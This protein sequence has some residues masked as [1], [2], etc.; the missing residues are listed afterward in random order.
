MEK[1]DVI[2][3]LTEVA[4]LTVSVNKMYAQLQL[5]RSAI[6]T[7]IHE[8]ETTP[9]APDEPAWLIEYLQGVLENLK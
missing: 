9:D 4:S 3:T 7:A 6:Q 5:A 8:L 2:Q 1:I